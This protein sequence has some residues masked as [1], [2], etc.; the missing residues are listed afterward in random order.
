[1]A[2]KLNVFAITLTVC[3]VALFYTSVVRSRIIN[4]INTVDYDDNYA[5]YYA[6]VPVY[7]PGRQCAL[8]GGLCVQEEDCAP[9]EATSKKGLCPDKDMGVECCYQVIPRPSTCQ[10]QGGACMD[11]CNPSLQRDIATDCAPDQ[12]C[13]VLV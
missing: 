6:G 12:K 8:V 7:T 3:I 10:R 4:D 1:M 9:G 5:G 2:F 13:C 11:W